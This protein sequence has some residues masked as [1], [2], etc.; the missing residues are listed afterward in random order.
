[1]I[2]IR[3]A[4]R[5]ILGGA[6]LLGGVSQAEFVTLTADRDTT[7]YENLFAETNPLSN[8]AGGHFLAGQ[9]GENNDFEA[10]R[11]LLAFD[12]A[13]AIPVNAVIE[14]AI[15]QLAVSRAPP[16]AFMDGR[17]D[18]FALHRALT[19][20]GEGASASSPPEGVGAGALPGDATWVHSQWD[21][22][23]TTSLRWGTPGG[24]FFAVPS[25]TR[26]IGDIGLYLFIGPGL[27]ADVQRW[28]NDSSSN[29]GW[30]LLG[31]EAG[32]K[33]M[34]RFNTKDQDDED[35]W[36]TLFVTYTVVPEPHT[37][38]LFLLGAV[39]LARRSISF[40]A[41]DS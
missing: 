13:G 11:G 39:S 10:R 23:S 38:L 37:F 28:V 9:T 40:L 32:D 35:S 20:W 27:T 30:F 24:D 36:P 31:N 26:L 1:M 19:T 15:L 14:S 12:I 29:H 16:P 2:K 7:I 17:E 8:G 6:C 3:L 25:V 34:R 18:P 21:G 5:M 4:V 41:D 33:S 22:A